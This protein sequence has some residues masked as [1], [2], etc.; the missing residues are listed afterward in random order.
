ME[1]IYLKWCDD[2]QIITSRGIGNGALNLQGLV[3]VPVDVAIGLLAL[4]FLALVELNRTV[5]DHE[6]FRF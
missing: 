5:S 4:H 1:E 3:I 2:Q 6:D